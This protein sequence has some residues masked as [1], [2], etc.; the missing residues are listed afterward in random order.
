MKKYITCA[1]VAALLTFGISGAQAA[2]KYVGEYSGTDN[3]ALNNPKAQ[4]QCWITIKKAGKSAYK[5][6]FTVADHFD[7]NKVICKV[8]F[9]LK[10]GMAEDFNS[11]TVRKG[12]VGQYNGNSVNL[13]ADE[14][15]E[16]FMVGGIKNDI[17][18]GGKFLWSGLYG[19]I[20]D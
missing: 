3:C 1:A 10:P 6:D 18:C 5:V 14:P 11:R 4:T 8:S 12:L 19:Q 2:D 9:R 16:I 13:F 20:G 17:V 15:G 7:A